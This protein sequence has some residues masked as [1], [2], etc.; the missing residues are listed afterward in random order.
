MTLRTAYKIHKWFAVTVGAFIAL[1]LISGIV[2]VLPPL[3]SAEVPMAAPRPLDVRGVTV[4]P[5]EAA[6]VLSKDLG[7]P[8]QVDSVTLRRVGGA[9]VYEVMAGSAGPHLI[10][11]RAGR[12]FTITP[13]V[14]EEVARERFPSVGR[15]VERDQV[16][17]HTLEYPWGSLPAHRIVFDLDPAVPYYV[18]ATN[19]AVVRS[20]RWTR[21]QGVMGSLHTFEPLKLITT[22]ERARKGLLVLLSVVGIGVAGTGYYLALPRR[23]VS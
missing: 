21:F 15:V 20:D 16:S 23:R 1:W 19:G 18:S 5:A 22:S 10:D 12:V 7:R 13:E 11:A 8:L 6:E 17:R 3:F 14:A 2:M 4:T 9:T